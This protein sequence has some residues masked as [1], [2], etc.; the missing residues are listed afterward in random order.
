[1][2]NQIEKVFLLALQGNWQ[3]LDKSNKISFNND[4]INVYFENKGD[5]KWSIEYIKEC[6]KFRLNNNFNSKDHSIVFE[7]INKDNFV[8]YVV[9]RESNSKCI[10]DENLIGVIFPTNSSRFYKVNDFQ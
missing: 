4:K 2:E 1:M 10:F 6:D 3:T 7:E 5:F 8:I 9:N